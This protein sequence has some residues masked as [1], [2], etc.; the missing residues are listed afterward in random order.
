MK[1]Q[2]VLAAAFVVLISIPAY[3]EDVKPHLP[4]KS[5][6]TDTAA[7]DPR[8]PLEWKLAEGYTSADIVDGNVALQA[9]TG[10]NWPDERQAIVTFWRAEYRKG[11]AIIRC[12]D[13]FDKHMLPT[14]GKC[15]YSKKN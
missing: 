13:Y 4:E 12:I 6:V 1:K 11:Q 3:A 10:L 14:G 7:P 5:A 15:E 8:K 2:F 9:S